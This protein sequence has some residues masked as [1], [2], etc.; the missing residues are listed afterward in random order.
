MAGVDKAEMGSMERL[1][2][3][4]LQDDFVLCVA[5]LFALLVE[6]VADD[7]PAA[8]CQMDTDLMCASGAQ[9][10]GEQAGAFIIGAA[11]SFAQAILCDGFFAAE[12]AHGHFAPM[13]RMAANGRI[14]FGGSGRR[15]SP[16]EGE[17]FAC[18]LAVL[19]VAG[20]LL[21]ES[22]MGEIGFSGDDQAACIHIKA[23]DDAGALL[24]ANA[25]EASAAM[26]EQRIDERVVAMAARR[27][28][29][30][31]RRFVDHDQV[32]IFIDNIKLYCAGR[33]RGWSGGWYRNFEEITG[34]NFDAGRDERLAAF[35]DLAGL[36][37]SGDSGTADALGQPCC[38]RAGQ[39][40]IGAQALIF[41][42]RGDVYNLLGV[43]R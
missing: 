36:D 8:R 20:E 7:R 34:G 9:A 12:F 5:F 4:R 18:E 32:I 14:N 41:L 38:E 35:L 22:V 15:P 42:L 2:L 13:D 19:S 23:V 27:M 16:N 17:I 21:C 37:Q 26:V 28:N 1:A 3:D 31:A 33:D 10:A 11:E 43:H 39:E 40:Q 24:A 29:R 25:G 6:R 30:Q